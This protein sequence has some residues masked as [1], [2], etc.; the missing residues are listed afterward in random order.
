MPCARRRAGVRG[1]R[2]LGGWRAVLCRARRQ[3]P[4]AAEVAAAKHGAQPQGG[5]LG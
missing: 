1:A 3:P 5:D 4:T 2:A